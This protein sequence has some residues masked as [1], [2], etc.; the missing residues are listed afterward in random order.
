MNTGKMARSYLR[1]ARI[2]LSQSKSS[3]GNGDYDICVR[4]AQEAVE[5]SLKALLRHLSIEYP[6]DHDAGPVLKENMELLPDSIK[7]VIDW[8]VK[9]SD[10]M[11]RN[12]GPAFY[13]IEEG[14]IPSTELFTEE[15]GKKA[16][17]E[18]M[19]I[20]KLVEET[21]SGTDETR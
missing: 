2:C 12:R 5:M 1:N 20:L 11:S 13:G 3:L 7:Q 15:D 4:R 8:L 16:F 21:L 17:D 14:L 18:A 10:E 19:Q 6:R 9:V